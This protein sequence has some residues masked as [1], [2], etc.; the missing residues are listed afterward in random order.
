MCRAHGR[1]APFAINLYRCHAD[2]HAAVA[3]LAASGVRAFRGRGVARPVPGV[4]SGALGGVEERHFLRQTV[5][6]LRQLSA[7]CGHLIGAGRRLHG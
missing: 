5:R 1:R 2:P 3:E 4:V 6:Q 7:R